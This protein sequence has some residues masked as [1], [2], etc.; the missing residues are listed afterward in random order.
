M[1]LKELF[2]YN[3]FAFYSLGLIAHSKFF[4]TKSILFKFVHIFPIW[5]AFIL[6]LVF[7]ANILL[8]QSVNK[9]YFNW[10]DTFASFL[11]GTTTLAVIFNPM[12]A[13]IE[14]RNEINQMEETFQSIEFYLHQQF[15]LTL[16]FRDFLKCF[17]GKVLVS[18][19]FVALTVSMVIV[20]PRDNPGICFELQICYLRL[21][22]TITKLYVLF[23][24]NLLTSLMKL[25][26]N[27]NPINKDMILMFS[28]M[29][30]KDIKLVFIQ[31]KIVHLKFFMVSSY[32]NSIFGWCLTSIIAQTLIDWSYTSYWVFYY[33]DKAEPEQ[34]Y[35]LSK[36]WF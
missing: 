32:I 16:N 24:V 14:S 6:S 36:Y 33:L 17:I 29:D 23:H 30:W 34:I 27:F 3:Q 12:L 4:Y 10:T 26:V 35:A 9:L 7:T 1:I 20:L 13:S 15:H 19:L 31:Y 18:M 21:Y 11:V 28:K 25:F 22:A 2:S 8:I 5:V